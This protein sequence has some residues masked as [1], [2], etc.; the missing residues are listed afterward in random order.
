[1]HAVKDSGFEG[2]LISL[3]TICCLL[4]EDH[5]ISREF[6]SQA[7]SQLPCEVQAVESLAQ[8]LALVTLQ[9]FDLWLC[10]MH[11]P[12]AEGSAILTQLRQAA[13]A[14]SKNTQAIAI[15]A[16]LAKDV[17]AELKASGFVDVLSKPI[18]IAQL[19]SAVR[20]TAGIPQAMGHMDSTM[21]WDDAAAMAAVG[22]QQK[23]LTA[24]RE[25]FISDL[26]KQLALIQNAYQHKDAT[27][28]K[29]E[30]HKLMAACGFVGAAQLALRAKN[31]SAALSDENHLSA[32][33]ENAKHYLDEGLG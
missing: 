17:S 24:L 19:H 29:S 9:H 13:P 30:L 1:L 8:A 18:S 21:R 14:G 26:P 11:L 2:K 31:L 6:L 28:M 10:D 32:F 5:A 33:V 3:M 4:I 22:G 16:D 12:D 15:T 20:R 23:I 27:T 7:L 25:M